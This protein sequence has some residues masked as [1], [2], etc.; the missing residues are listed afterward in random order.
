VH[1]DVK[2]DNVLIAR[3]PGDGQLTVKLTDF[4]ISYAASAPSLTATNASAAAAATAWR[5][6]G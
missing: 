4:G 1:R 6:S 5:S 2:P 3:L